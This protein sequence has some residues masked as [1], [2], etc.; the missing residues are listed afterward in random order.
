M[1]TPTDGTDLGPSTSTLA[2]GLRLSFR[3]TLP[4]TGPSQ[5]PPLR[6]AHPAD[7][8][9]PTAPAADGPG[10]SPVTVA[11]ALF[12][13]A[14]VCFAILA[15]TVTPTPGSDI[16][17]LRSLLAMGA[18][19]VALVLLTLSVAH[20]QVS[21]LRP[22]S[23]VMGIVALGVGQALVAGVIAGGHDNLWGVGAWV[24][25]LIGVIVP[26]TWVGSQFQGGVR[27]QR[28]E[29]H[30][31]LMATWIERARHQANQTVE[32]AH[33]HDVRSMLFVIDGAGRTMADDTLSPEQRASFSEM[34]AE[35]V[36]RL[37]Q[38]M[39]VRSEEIQPFAVDGVTRAVVHAERKVGRTIA[40]DLPAGLRALGRV[41][42]V[43]AVLRTLVNVTGR[44]APG[45]VRIQGE[46][47]D[48]TVVIRIE[49]AGADALPLLIGNWEEIWAESFKATRNDDEESIDLYVA[50]RLL[51]E[52]GADLWTTSGRVRFAVRL[53]VV[54]VPGSQEEA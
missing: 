24:F 48:G 44:K 14:W 17:G 9:A 39:D 10:W 53:P 19:V 52:Q 36:Q 31:N 23:A 26:L 41:A 54:A 25:V 27:R 6:S 7:P 32:S 43:T 15:A 51:E 45:G 11:A 38:L 2:T 47:K 21:G 1:G 34:H 4:I 37:G 18:G 50:A 20:A 3:S 29:Q 16:A 22:R 28:V 8:A 30:A 33:R 42:D 12:A 46:L 49:P 40:S 13:A 5:L 35:S